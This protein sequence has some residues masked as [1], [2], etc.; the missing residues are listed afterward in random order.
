[1]LGANTLL[2]APLSPRDRRLRWGWLGVWS[3]PFWL[4]IAVWL[5]WHPAH[6]P[7]PFQALLH[8]PSP[9]C[10]LTRSLLAFWRGDW[11]QSFAYHAF[12]IPLIVVSGGLCLQLGI[13]LAVGRSVGPRHSLLTTYPRWLFQPRPIAIGLAV[14]FAYYALRLYARYT[15]GVLPFQLDQTDLWQIVVMGA[16]LI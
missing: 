13:E 16:K 8:F 5:G 9:T 4:A 2:N 14:L 15:A 10:G 1:M 6:H 11:Q 3:V 7:C 12:G